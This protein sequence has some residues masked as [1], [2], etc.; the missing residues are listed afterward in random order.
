MLGLVVSGVVCTTR[1]PTL[2]SIR[3]AA[4]ARTT[5]RTTL[6]VVVVSRPQTLLSLAVVL[7]TPR[8][9]TP[10]LCRC[11]LVTCGCISAT[12]AHLRLRHL[13]TR[14]VYEAHWTW[15]WSVWC[16]GR[17]RGLRGALD[18]VVVVVC[19]ARWTWS[20]SWRLWPCELPSFIVS[21]IQS[22]STGRR[23]QLCK[24]E[25]STRCR[26]QLC[27][28]E[29]R[30]GGGQGPRSHRMSTHLDIGAARIGWAT[31][32]VISISWWLFQQNRERD[33]DHVWKKD[34]IKQSNK[35][36]SLNANKPACPFRLVVGGGSRVGGRR[37]ETDRELG[38][39]LPYLYPPV[40]KPIMAHVGD[41]HE[42]SWVSR[43]QWAWVARN[44]RGRHEKGEPRKPRT[45]TVLN[46]DA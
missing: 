29:W 6:V 8:V 25:W 39:Q 26:T 28:E 12:T 34:S 37:E 17:G 16:I 43:E 33:S 19:G 7:A 27:E 32:G 24:E 41:T 40:L 22:H 30:G 3:V 13:L 21:F 38:K 10:T 18:V 36:E 20:C 15:S 31:R 11:R 4:E 35:K 1:S 45:C 23:T 14:L 9:E 44:E 5:T 2:G 46:T 42:L